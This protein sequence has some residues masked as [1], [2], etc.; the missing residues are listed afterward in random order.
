[1]AINF[2]QTAEI[3]SE[4]LFQEVNNEAVILDLKS[5]S[6]YGL[7]EVGLRIWQMLGEQKTL[8]QINESLLDE[9]D[10]D[11]ETLTED[12]LKLLDD[13]EKAGLITLNSNS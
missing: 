11:A 6:Y 10:V 12:M 3:S 13:L 1:M 4:A 8:R 5:E 7:N 2:N 9:F